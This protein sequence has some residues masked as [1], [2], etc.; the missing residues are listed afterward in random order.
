MP[1]PN[2]S[3]TPQNI[4]SRRQIRVKVMQALYAYEASG[5]EPAVV[6]ELLLKDMYN[7]IL[8]TEKE[9]PF[10]GDSRLLQ[11]LFHECIKNADRYDGYVKKRAA[12]WE[13]ARIARIDRILLHMGICEMLNFEEIPIKVTMNEYLDL[14]KTF[15]TPKSS[16]FVNGILDGLFQDFRSTGLIV[17]SGRGLVDHSSPRPDSPAVTPPEEKPESPAQPE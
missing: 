16:K 12:N 11:T 17:K 3:M 14:A 4:V 5:Q 6:Y 9:K 2:D 7:E 8:A 13:L 15:S 1:N 10:T